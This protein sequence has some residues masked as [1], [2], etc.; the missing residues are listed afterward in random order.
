[1]Q[2]GLAL[3]GIIVIWIALILIVPLTLISGKIQDR[4]A[5]QH[6]ARSHIALSWTGEQTL[7]SPLLILPYLVE[8]TNYGGKDKDGN[9]ITKVSSTWHKRYIVP[10]TVAIDVEVD[11]QLRKQG[12]YGI[13]VYTA[14]LAINGRISAGTLTTILEDLKGQAGFSRLGEPLLSLSVADI[15]GIDGAPTLTWEDQQRP[16]E[17]NSGIDT[18]ESGIHASLPPLE[19]SEEVEF[20]LHLSLRGME[21][22]QFVPP[23]KQVDVSLRSPWPHPQFSGA[24]LPQ[25]R[26]I[27]AQGFSAHWRVNHFSTGIGQLMTKCETGSCYDLHNIGFEVNFIE[28]VDAYLQAERSLK[29]GILFIGLSFIAFFMFETL[30]GIAI[31]PVQYTLVGFALAVF[32]L[33]LTSLSEHI[34]FAFAYLIATLACLMLLAYYLRFVLG[35]WKEAGIFAASL[36]T[37]YGVLFVIVGA[38][39]FALLMGSVLIFAVLAGI[40]IVTRKIDWYGLKSMSRQPGISKD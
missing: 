5:Y 20:Q 35:R 10:D 7:I 33:L 31:H 11:T 23:A 19:F 22:L 25:S 15:R 3:K 32:F 29:Y 17:S 13:P 2:K 6:E 16:F 12:I 30:R 4:R 27:S 1:M 40:M 21:S 26:E 34:P 24:F 37:L 9:P 38:E 36:A 39:D 28:A 8:T 14:G 18:L